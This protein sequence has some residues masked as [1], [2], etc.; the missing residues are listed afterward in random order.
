MENV[1][2]PLVVEVVD[3]VGSG[4]DADAAKSSLDDVDFGKTVDRS[5]RSESSRT[6]ELLSMSLDE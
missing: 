1:R 5:L 3:G 4:V 2:V 6:A